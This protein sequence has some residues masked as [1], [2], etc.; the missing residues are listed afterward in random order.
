MKLPHNLE[1]EA[2]VLGKMINSINCVNLAVDELDCHDFYNPKSIAIFSAMKALY[3]DGTDITTLTVC[4]KVD[5]SSGVDIA[6]LY[7]LTQFGGFEDLEHFMAILKRCSQQRKVIHCLYGC[8]PLSEENKMEPQDVQAKIVKDLESIFS[9]VKTQERHISQ[10]LTENFRDSGLSLLD[11]IEK[12]QERFSLGQYTLQGLPSGYP[13]LDDTLDGFCK[14][15]Y[16]I[17]GARPG[18][19]KTTF[20]LNLIKNMA[21]KRIPIGFF[22]L[23]MT[24]DDVGYNLACLCAGIESKQ[25]KRGNIDF[26]QY[27]NL[28]AAVKHM[29]SFPLWI[30]DQSS[31][32]ISQL[33]ARAKRMKANHGIQVLFIDYLGEVK[34]DGK[35]PNRQ[36]QIQDVSK[37]LRGL[38]KDL[39]IPIICICQLNRESEKDSRVPRKSDLR[40]SGQ[41]EAD[42]HSILLLHRPDQEDK[43]DKPGQVQLHIVKNRFGEERRIDFAFKKTTGEI[44]EYEYNIQEPKQEREF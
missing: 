28:V 15:H 41:I 26:T 2:V 20:V 12:Q 4:D 5:P 31:L 24:S 40:E 39:K 14:G 13:R 30:E 36:E 22:S 34:G 38:A 8:L 42:A 43:F 35:Y 23:E 44:L 16:I 37:S 11:F 17:I 19:G 21:Q 29:E 33:C 1:S 9:E 27:Q 6:Y 7:G 3:V 18:S 10:I 25:A 32:R